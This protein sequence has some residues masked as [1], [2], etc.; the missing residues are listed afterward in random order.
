MTIAPAPSV[1][2]LAAPADRRTLLADDVRTGLTASPRWLPPK[3][4]YDAR[5]SAL[6]E[7]ITELPEYY[8]TRVETALLTRI[9]GPVID[10]VRPE[11]LVE[12]GSGSST[13]T[14]LLLEAMHRHGG[15][16]YAPVDVSVD[17]LAGAAAALGADYPWLAFDG[18]VGDFCADLARLP[19]GGR[20]LLAF[21][22][23]TIGNY[24]PPERAELLASVAAALADGDRFLLGV[25]LVKDR[26]ALVAAYD[27]A[28]G[29]TAEF[30]LNM[31]R[32][33]ARE[34]EADIKVEAFEHVALW[35]EEAAWIEMRLRATEPVT[36]RF[37]SLDLEVDFEAGEELRTEISA[38]FTRDG[39]EAELA[40]AGLRLERW[41]SDD[42]DRFALALAT[43]VR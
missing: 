16:R 14:R 9:A 27:D 1:T 37:P 5:G 13:K 6:F 11:E 12:L 42:Q 24:A 28:A 35:D 20:R 34:L 32:V 2:H 29:V 25:D 40:A 31:L 17:A 15:S 38:K 30:N 23:S 7:L 26:G 39:V 22:G 19:H 21:L 3:W 43:G 36:L 41:D 10:L 8:P 33:L 4:F 18:Y